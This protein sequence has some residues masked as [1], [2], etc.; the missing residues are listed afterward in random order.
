[1]ETWILSHIFFYDVLF[2]VNVP[3]WFCEWSFPVARLT[4]CALR[5]KIQPR[6]QELAHNSLTA[7][8]I[9][10]L[11]A[12]VNGFVCLDAPEP[13]VNKLRMSIS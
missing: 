6:P 2:F 10:C 4:A 11:A 3:G 13:N 5:T 9:Q 7:F 8:Q 1:M 12:A